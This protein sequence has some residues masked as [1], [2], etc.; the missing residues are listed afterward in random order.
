MS[1]CLRCCGGQS[2]SIWII[3]TEMF[4]GCRVLSVCNRI[5]RIGSISKFSISECNE[6][7]LSNCR[8]QKTYEMFSISEHNESLLFNCQ[9]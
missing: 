6:S 4:N 7:L 1:V 2:G 9:A 3:F 5:N 8:A